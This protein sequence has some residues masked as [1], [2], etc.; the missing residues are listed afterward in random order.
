MPLFTKHRSH[1]TSGWTKGNKH[2]PQPPKKEGMVV[3]VLSTPLSLGWGQSQPQKPLVSHVSLLLRF[4]V[5]FSLVMSCH[6]GEQRTG[7]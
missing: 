7:L 5:S 4:L 2:A 3:N 6:L 1:N